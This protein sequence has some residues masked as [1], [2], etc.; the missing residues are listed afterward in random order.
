MNSRQPILAAVLASCLL[1]AAWGSAADAPPTPGPRDRCAICGMFVAKHPSWVATIVYVDGSARHFDGPKD[2]FR[3][4][5]RDDAE[6]DRETGIWV[7]DYYTT[8]PLK[9]RDAVF[10]RGSDVLGPMGAELVPLASPELAESFRADHGGD[11]PLT[12]DDIDADLL[13]ALE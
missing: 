4:R 13:E 7:T 2:L 1:V 11:P 9:A 3:F 6:T 8:R 5:A 12:F 10:V